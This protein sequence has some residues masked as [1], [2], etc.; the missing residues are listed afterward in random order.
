MEEGYVEVSV[1][2]T[3]ETA[4]ALADFLF[5]EGALGLVI[6]DPVDRSPEIL[7]RASFRG[8]PSIKPI[9]ARLVQY[10][11]E[12]KTLGLTGAVG[13]IETHQIPSE[14]W[15]KTWK[16][17]F[18]PLAVGKRLV[19]VPP[20]EDGAFPEDRLLLR[21]DPGM[22]FG[23]GHHATTR[24]C[25]EALETFME[26]WGGTRK[27]VVL[28]LGTGTGILAIA[29]AVLGAEHVV[30]IDAD[31]EAC[32][33]AIR[34][35]TLNNVT[36]RIR[37]CHGGVENLDAGVQFD[38]VLANLDLKGICPLFENLSRLL[39]PGG[40]LV[41]SGILVEEEGAVAA[42]ARAAGLGVIA[43]QS[44]GEWLCLT[45]ASDRWKR[46]LRQKRSAT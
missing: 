29:A 7:M 11:K 13:R 41:A 12:L 40:R 4:E 27:P 23:T 26:K 38:L 6:E 17:H 30:A 15:G 33:A 31:S 39:L 28:D 42:A 43:R 2:A 25:L 45:L 1:T 3:V 22:S 44:D 36:N 8:S 32:Q 9:V 16:E 24:M 46:G 35:L 20:W 21:V 34:N 18:R 5:S 19:I 10:Q 37:L 14:D